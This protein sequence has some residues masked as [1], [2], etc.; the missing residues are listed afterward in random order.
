MAAFCDQATTQV[1]CQPSP[2][3][4]HSLLN[5]RRMFSSD[6]ASLDSDYAWSDEKDIY[7]ASVADASDRNSRQCES[8]YRMAPI[9]EEGMAANIAMFIPAPSSNGSPLSTLNRNCQK[10]GRGRGPASTLLCR[11]QALSEQYTGIQAQ[12]AQTT[13]RAHAHCRAISLDNVPQQRPRNWP[14]KPGPAIMPNRPQYPA[15]RR[16]PT[17]PGLPSFNTPEACR[18]ANQFLLRETDR[19]GGTVNHGNNRGRSLN[20]YVDAI[21]R[22]FGSSTTVNTQNT[23]QHY[24]GIGRADDGTIVH[25][26]FPFRQSGHN[27]NMAR[28]IHDHPFAQIAP[29]VAETE[30]VSTEDFEREK[31]NVPNRRQQRQDPNIPAVSSS[32]GASQLCHSTTASCVLVDQQ[33]RPLSF[34]ETPQASRSVTVD[35]RAGPSPATRISRH[36]ATSSSASLQIT[37]TA[38]NDNN[39]TARISSANDGKR[40]VGERGILIFAKS[41]FCCLPKANPARKCGTEAP[42]LEA[43]FSHES[44]QVLRGRA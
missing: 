10:R 1:V 12:T 24:A 17:P 5:V 42:S 3:Q 4:R 44:Q 43:A 8:D 2:P 36:V 18:L 27:V 35:D 26:R 32:R 23:S 22:F 25:G 31:N 28:N 13:H 11:D 19:A 14:G 29:V 16:V 7:N 39:T 34:S 33:G 41:I 37:Q 21:R 20:S 15:P 9:L 30:V 6:E 38:G 40:S